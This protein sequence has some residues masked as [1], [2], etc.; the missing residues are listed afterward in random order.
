MFGHT[1]LN[2]VSLNTWYHCV[3]TLKYIT[4]SST[5]IKSYFNGNLIT[6]ETVNSTIANY[7][8][9]TVNNFISRGAG[10][11]IAERI[12]GNVDDFRIY[13]KILEINEVYDLYNGNTDRSYP[14]LKDAN[15]LTINPLAWYKF[16]SDGITTD[17]SGNGYTLTNNGTVVLNTNDFVKGNASLSM[18]ASTQY[19]NNSSFF[20]ITNKSWSVSFWLKKNTNTVVDWL[21][22]IGD[23]SNSG[24][25]Q[26]IIYDSGNLLTVSDW[27]TYISASSFQ[28]AGSWHHIVV[29]YATG[30]KTITIYRNGSQIQQGTLAN[31]QSPTNHSFLV[32]AVNLTATTNNLKGLM[33]DLRF[34]DQTLTATQVS[35]L[36]N[37]RLSIY[38]PPAFLTGFELEDE[39]KIIDNTISSY[40]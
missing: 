28:M 13:N 29:S 39:S 17:T 24:S 19:L 22:S 20:N 4:A 23:T 7:T 10:A 8:T 25:K 34:Y 12:S 26:V 37:G 16:D 15:N 31:E 9:S 5:E 6:T 2:S 36:Y 33:D 35:E 27:N 38:N 14:I 30:S 21:V 11:G 3:L 1:L 32:G 40:K 18:S